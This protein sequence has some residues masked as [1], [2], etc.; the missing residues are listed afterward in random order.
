MTGL[1]AAGW[2]P[3]VV[4]FSGPLSPGGSR[5]RQRHPDH[6]QLDLL[7]ERNCSGGCAQ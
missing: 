3:L 6:D 4:L 7:H 5:A 1:A 2:V